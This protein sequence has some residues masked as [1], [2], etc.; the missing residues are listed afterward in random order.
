MLKV[1]TF[2]S[3]YPSSEMPQLGVFVEN[4]LRHLLRDTDIESRV[5]SPMPWF[6]F[7]H[8]LDKKYEKYS[9]IPRVEKRHEIKIT[10]S[11]YFH[12]PKIGMNIQ[13]FSMAISSYPALKK[14]IRE[15]YDF[16]IIDAHYFY[17]DGVAAVLLA[18]M[19]NK[20]VVIT[21]R[22]SD[23]NVYRQYIVPRTLIKWASKRASA[24]I[25][26]CQA[27]KN[28]LSDM[29]VAEEK[30]TVLRNG[31]DL[32]LFQPQKNR[33]QARKSLGLDGKVLLM[34]GRLISLKG[35]HLAIQALTSFENMTLII[36]GEGEEQKSLERL[37]RKLG[38]ANRVRFLG[39]VSHREL[40][41]C[42][43]AADALLLASSSE[44]WANVILE[45]MACGTPVVATNVGGTSEIVSSPECGVL[46]EERSPDAIATGLKNLFNNY[47]DR[48]KTREYAE[49]FSWL[50]TS[51]GQQELFLKII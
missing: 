35:H 49:K 47:P 4:R 14:I 50:E 8:Y 36:I 20:P 45:S 16:D 15:G 33:I 40:P 22:G 23:L 38:L 11:K 17:P 19:L 37:A 41:A 5:F 2:T 3:L 42:Y 43:S 10:H 27:L 6:P 30:V 26:V 13:A 7:S 31:V 44:G 9:H 39:T 29:S 51:L 24:L 12:V 46:V 48:Q 28:V 18:K 25:T 32:E 1:L 21:A 34:V